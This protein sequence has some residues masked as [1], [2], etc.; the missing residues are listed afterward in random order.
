MKND[1]EALV[2]HLNELIK[3]CRQYPE[4]ERAANR[5]RAYRYC[6]RQLKVV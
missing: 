1:V 2:R 3:I 4:N 5:A 6:V